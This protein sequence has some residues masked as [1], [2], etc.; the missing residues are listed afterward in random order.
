MSRHISNTGNHL[1][2]TEL[3]LRDTACGKLLFTRVQGLF[4]ALLIRDNRL[5]AVQVLTQKG[6]KIGAVYIGKVKKIVKNIEACFVEIAEKEICFL[7][8]KEARKAFLI[9]RTSDGR[10]LEGDELLVQISRD[11]H[12]KKCASVTAK[13]SLAN[14]AFAV[15][16]QEKSSVGYSNKL[17]AAEKRRLQ[18]AMEHLNL[19]EYFPVPV[20]LIV[21]TQAAMCT[22]SELE[23]SLEELS[24]DWNSLFRDARHRVCFSCLKA[25]LGDLE[26]IFQQMAYT[27]EYEEIVTD[28]QEFC[29]QLYAYVSKHLPDKK[30]RLYEDQ[31]L[32]LTSL[33]AL[34]TKLK[35]ALD[36]RVWLKSGAYLVIE[37]T[38]AMTVIDVNSG[39]LAAN[40]K[41]A[42]EEIFRINC[43]AAR[44]IALQLRLRN[45]SGIILVDFIN[46][47]S[48]D[49]QTEL[50]ELTRRLV[51][52]DRQKTAV[53]DI[54]P[55]GLMEITRKRCQRSLQEQ[56]TIRKRQL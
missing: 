33:Y 42:Q 28:D 50:L 54:T 7:S 13:V 47:D 22:E 40:K 34:E 5:T 11:A 23:H 4:C 24:V 38:E 1:T 10:I 25:G 18:N 35:E 53:I 20:S 26:T 6:G 44:E 21:R 3:Q 19:L 12:G 27:W 30:V 8:L 56:L 39:K 55:L 17:S 9:N 52:E 49:R 45:L 43:E 37:P 36:P 14:E 41:K 51:Q 16:R 48:R 46:M 2:Q 29:E 15:E 31:A 32:S